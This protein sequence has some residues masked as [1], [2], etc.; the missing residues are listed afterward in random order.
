MIIVLSMRSQK[1]LATN[2]C[3]IQFGAVTK[4]GYSEIVLSLKTMLQIRW[5]HTHDSHAMVID[6]VK[7]CDREKHEVNP[8]ALRKIGVP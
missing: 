8:I 7:A 6:L 3:R 2:A 1:S 4:V 5:E